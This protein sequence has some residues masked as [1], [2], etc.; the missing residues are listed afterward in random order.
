MRVNKSKCIVVKAGTNIL[1]NDDN[2]LDL[3][4]LREISYQIAALNK[5]GYKIILVTSGAIVT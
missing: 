4:N 2:L 1:T 3:N 5:K